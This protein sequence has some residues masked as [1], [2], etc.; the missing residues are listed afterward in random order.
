MK[1]KK[2]KKQKKA[3]E[4]L[5]FF[6]VLLGAFAQPTVHGASLQKCGKYSFVPVRKRIYSTRKPAAHHAHRLRR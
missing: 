1:I 3:K 4:N 6:A 2:K 5:S